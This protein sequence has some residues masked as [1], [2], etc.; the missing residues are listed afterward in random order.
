MTFTIKG[1]LAG[2]NE[3]I[4]ASRYNRYIGA[5]MKK[6]NDTDVRLQTSHLKPIKSYPIKICASFY[7]PNARRDPDNIL[8]GAMKSILDALQKN[9][10][11]RNDGHHEIEE[12]HAYFYTSKKNPRIEIELKE[13]GEP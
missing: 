4:E 1:R 11:L 2:M 9:G 3:I 13:A 7:E 10:V 6:A 8:S 5:R 12:I